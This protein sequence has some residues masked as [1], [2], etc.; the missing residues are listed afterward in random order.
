MARSA[1][2]LVAAALAACLAG[3][4]AKAPVVTPGAPRY[5]D[6]PFPAVPQGTQ[7]AAAVVGAHEQAWALLQSGDARRAAQGFA[8]VLKKQPGFYPSRAGAG[9]VELARQDFKAALAAFDAALKSAPQYGPALVGRG[10]ALFGLG[11]EAEGLA[12]LEAA[13]VADPGLADVQRRVEA[14]RFR[15]VQEAIGAAQAAAQAGR[16]EEAR[17]RYLGALAASPDSAFLYRDLAEVERRAGR[18]D[19]A[20]AHAQEAVARDPSDGSAQLLLGEVFEEQ[21]LW[22]DAL[23]AYEAAQRLDAG[24]ETADRI[25]RVRQRSEAARLPGEYRAIPEASRVTRGDL[26]A[27]IGIR[28]DAFTRASSRSTPVL[29]TDVRGHW[30]QAWILAVVRAGFMEVYNNHTFQPRATVRRS[31]LAQAVS[32]VLATVAAHDP[33]RSA[34]WREARVRFSD[35]GPGHLHYAAASTAV[36]AGVLKAADGEAFQ[37]SRPIT[38]AEAVDAVTRLEPIVE[39]LASSLKPRASSPWKP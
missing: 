25:A 15:R 2:V 10:D 29:V 22:D 35:I 6:Y 31:D 4:A 12:S 33:A 24:P 37:P 1:F 30:A 8:A 3:C 18:V 28:L 38:G 7:T 11:R 17:A 26:A 27:L 20:L 16:W 32:R 13:V 34:A 39:G 19:D 5:P 14:L 23:K 21:G 9:F 36:A